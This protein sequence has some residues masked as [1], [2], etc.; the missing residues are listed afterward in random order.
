MQSTCLRSIFCDVRTR[1]L[2]R[3]GGALDGAVPAR[4]DSCSLLPHGWGRFGTVATVPAGRTWL[5]LIARRRNAWGCMCGAWDLLYRRRRAIVGR[6]CKVLAGC[7]GRVV[8]T[9]APVSV[10]ALLGV[11]RAMLAAMG[12]GTARL[13]RGRR[14]RRDERCSVNGGCSVRTAARTTKWG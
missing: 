13:W 10:A 2:R 14:F 1:F 4:N 12:Y 6:G 11:G 8:A 7:G 3:E 9:A 5:A